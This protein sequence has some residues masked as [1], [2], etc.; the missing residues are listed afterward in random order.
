MLDY[1][2]RIRQV[3]YMLYNVL[4]I[5]KIARKYNVTLYAICH[6]SILAMEKKSQVSMTGNRINTFSIEIWL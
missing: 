1:F 5:F 4:C 3:V 6:M 2:Y